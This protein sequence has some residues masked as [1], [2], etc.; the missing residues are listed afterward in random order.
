VWI[1]NSCVQSVMAILIKSYKAFLKTNT[2]FWPCFFFFF[3]RFVPVFIYIYINNS[4]PKSKSPI[5]TAERLNVSVLYWHRSGRW[6][7]GY[8]R[9]K[10]GV[11]EHVYKQHLHHYWL[12]YRPASAATRQPAGIFPAGQTTGWCEQ[13]YAFPCSTSLSGDNRNKLAG[14]K[15]EHVNEAEELTINCACTYQYSICCQQDAEAE[16]S[17][18]RN[19]NLSSKH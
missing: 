1:S 12:S 10:I 18:A 13:A 8:S 3:F 17:C 14:L 2:N 9:V 15:T 11:C 6:S 16:I 19:Q 7:L 4:M 5:F